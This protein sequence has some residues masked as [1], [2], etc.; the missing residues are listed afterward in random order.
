MSSSVPISGH[1]NFPAPT[2]QN[3]PLQR[4]TTGIPSGL[5]RPTVPVISEDGEDGLDAPTDGADDS[6]AGLQQHMV[7]MVQSRLAGLVGKS[8]GYI[9]GLPVDVKLNVEALKGIQCQYYELQNKYRLECLA[10]ERKVYSLFFFLFGFFFLLWFFWQSNL[11][12]CWGLCSRQSILLVDLSI[13]P[14]LSEIESAEMLLKPYLTISRHRP[15]SYF[16]SS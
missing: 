13:H 14:R 12:S 15:H 8:S 3:T 11:P 1:G 16:Y 7:G 5:S 4:G 10:L 6:L 2:P 9:E